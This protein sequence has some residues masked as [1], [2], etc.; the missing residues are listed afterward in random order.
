[1]PFT[2]LLLLFFFFQ[3][4]RTNGYITD[5]QLTLCHENYACADLSGYRKLP[6]NLNQDV[7]DSPLLYLH[8][9]QDVQQS[10]LTG[11]Q[12]AQNN[13]SIPGWQRLDVNLNQRL[14]GSG[15][16]LYLFYTR[17]TTLSPITSIL[18]KPGESPIVAPEY[19]RLPFDLNPDGASFFLFYSQDGPQDPITAITAKECFTSHCYLEGW[20]RVEKDLNKGVMIGM[21]VY[22]FYQREKNQPSV[23]DVVIILNDQTTPEGYQKV[24]VNLNSVTLRGDVIYLWY[25]TGKTEEQPITQLAIEFGEHPIT[26]FGWQK[27]PTNLNSA[28]EGQDGFGEPTFLYFYRSYQELPTAHR[29]QFDQQGQ[30]KILQLADL[31]ITNEQG[32]CRDVLSEVSCKGDQTT[33]DYV[34]RVLEKEKPDL[35]IFSGDNI[36]AEG[37]TDARAATFKFANP[38]IQKKIPWA[39]IFGEED[40]TNDLCREELLQVMRR[41]P[42]SLIERGPMRLPG[43]GNYVLNIYSNATRTANQA[44]SLYLLDSHSRSEQAQEKYDTLQPS[45]LDWIAQTQKEMALANPQHRAAL[46]SH[47]PIWE[48]ASNEPKLGDARESVSTPKSDLSAL[49]TFKKANLQFASCGRDHVNDFCKEVFKVPLCYAGGAGVG[50][51]GAAHMGWPRRSRIFQLNRQGKSILTWK[52]LD[53]KQLSL[54][55]FQTIRLY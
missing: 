17:N 20:E 5:I 45:Q 13:N 41:M 9:R 14:S 33:L 7:P 15:S 21:S 3:V 35:V 54:L 48:Y 39:V 51:Y 12:L 36:N 42:Y 23:T 29:L 28:N 24:D 30:F 10:P 22:L 6:M 55:D 43:V 1:M 26:P 38:V 8:L 37:V 16:P 46:F 2:W 11:L 25:K 34:Q 52:R 50:G 49:N 40:D 47:A 53:N 31:H 18:I 4:N 27:I 19:T 32:E 44:F